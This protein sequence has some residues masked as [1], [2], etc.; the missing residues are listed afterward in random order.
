MT[1]GWIPDLARAGVKHAAIAAALGSAIEAGSLRPG[2]RLP[3]QRELAARLGVDLTTITKAYDAIRHRGLIEARGRAGSFVRAP[4]TVA[5]DELERADAGMNMPPE[6]PGNL[7][8]RTISAS[9]STLLLGGSPLRLQYQPAGGALQDRATG[10]SLLASMGLVS[11]AE[12]VLVTAGGQNALHAIL[13]AAL[14]PGDAVACARHVYP[15]FKALAARLGLELIPLPELTADALRE[16]C[17]AQTVKALYLVPTNDNPTTATLSARTR[18]E[19]AAAAEE[20][21]VQVIED[22]AYGALAP[23]PLAPISGLIPHRSW[24]VASTSKIISPALRVA[25]VRAPHSAAALRLAG[26]LHETTIMAPPLNVALVCQWIADGTWDRLVGLMRREAA[27]RQ[28]LARAILSGADYSSDPH[29]YH[30]WVRLSGGT[31]PG[32]VTELL[33]PTGLSAVPA[34]RFAVGPHSE[35]AVRISLGGPLSPERLADGLRLLRG[36]ERNAI[37]T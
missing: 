18:R 25:F 9:F 7:L 36:I 27:E 23:E 31:A 4:R 29:G 6:L 19:L 1:D 33:R 21:D 10:A 11:D 37:P 5:P 15:G 26:D 22:D 8:A 14:Q 28:A 17:A 24:Y 34:E 20:C 3:P 13:N 12:Q 35:A 2:E 32:A 30:L 16:A